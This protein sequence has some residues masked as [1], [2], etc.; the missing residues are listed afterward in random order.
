MKKMTA[1][2]LKEKS[3]PTDLTYKRKNLEGESPNEPP[4]K[5]LH[6]MDA[7]ISNRLPIE[8]KNSVENI[9]PSAGMKVTDVQPDGQD[10]TEDYA[11]YRLKLNG[12]NIAFRKGRITETKI[13]EFVALWKRPN[14]NPKSKPIPLDKNDVAYVVVSVA[15]QKHQG[16]F[17]FDTATLHK[18]GILAGDGKKGKTAFRLYPPWTK[19]DVSQAIKTQQ[20][21]LQYFLPIAENGTADITKA[22]KL[23]RTSPPTKSSEEEKTSA[24]GDIKNQP[25]SIEK[26]KSISKWSLG[27]ILQNPDKTSKSINSNEEIEEEETK[28]TKDYKK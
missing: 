18:Q 4:T 13:G 20:W 9:Y 12:Q 6:T 19:P 21:Q 7:P 23:F 16:Q 2:F 22:C 26:I 17:V 3:S 27:G 10:S 28:N 5:R 15:D 14:G 11:P 1:S 8:L 24:Q 25:T